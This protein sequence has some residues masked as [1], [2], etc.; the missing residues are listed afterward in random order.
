[1][2]LVM[3]WITAPYIEPIS[4]YY[5]VMNYAA[6]SM[7]YPY[8]ALKAIDV[9]IPRY[10]SNVI[11]TCQL[12]QMVIGLFLNMY[13]VYLN[14]WTSVDCFRHHVSMRLSLVVY[15]SF[16]LLFGKLFFDIVWKSKTKPK[17]KS[18]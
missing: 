3:C 16:T 10:I 5:V 2:T 9:K 18:S 7:M 14:N 4:R 1:M 13:T 17:E 12:S 6:H 8:F 11:T 15:G